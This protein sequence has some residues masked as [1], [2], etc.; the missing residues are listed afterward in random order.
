MGAG[1][2]DAQS[3]FA[4][5]KGRV[6]LGANAKQ[7][8]M[9]VF[10]HH[11]ELPENA[12]GAVVAIGNFDG[13]HLGH[14]AIIDAARAIA[15]AASAPLA[16]VTFEP[17]PRS[18]FAPQSPPFRLTPFRIKARLVESLG[19]D[20]L[21][22][23]TFDERL[24]HLSPDQFCADVLTAGLGIRHAV[25]G[26]NFVFGHRRAGDATMFRAL[27]AK[28]GFGVTCLERVAGPESEIYSSTRIREHLVAAAPRR[29]ARLLGRD[30][31]IE[32]R[33]QPGAKRGRD[34]GYPT[35]NLA[36]DEFLEPARGIYA[37]RA[38]IDRGD[39]IH[40]H[41]GVANM[42]VRPMFDGGTPLLEAHLFD[43]AED[44]YGKHLRVALVEYLRAEATFDTLETLVA[45]MGDDSRRARAILARQRSPRP[46]TV[47]P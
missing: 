9:R 15:R 21:F 42:G 43:F 25:V 12:R 33:V 29:A 20:L 32:G 1:P 30:W 44:L 28:L 26:A 37:V 8:P 27:G 19:V 6:S 22:V 5:P 2:F 10:R 39:T 40:W 31:E 46:D 38:G 7:G 14:Q 45:Q 13:V 17:H 24:S 4:G 11:T 36:L 18:F 34:L 3:G 23:L 47:R 16:V 35:A 41:D